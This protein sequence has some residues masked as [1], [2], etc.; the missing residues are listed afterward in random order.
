MKHITSSLLRNCS[1]LAVTSAL[2]AVSQSP[3]LAQDASLETVVVTGSHL[4]SSFN[5]P[6][7][8][9]VVDDARMQNLAIP[10]VADALNQLPSFRG[11]N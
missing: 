1:L 11:T 10:N 8:V 9:N 7:P 5:S 6:T 2:L 4:A 3:A